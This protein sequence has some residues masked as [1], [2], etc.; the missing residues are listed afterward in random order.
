MPDK[1]PKQKTSPAVWRK[2][3]TTYDDEAGTTL[4]ELAR[5]F[6]VSES[7]IR[8]HS[9]R[10][11]WRQREPE[12]RALPARQ[13]RGT[14]EPEGSALEVTTV[15]P[16]SLPCHTLPPGDPI[17]PKEFNE[18]LQTEAVSWL[19]VIAEARLAGAEIGYDTIELIRALVPQWRTAAEVGRKALGLDQ[20]IAGGTTV[21]VGILG[22]S[23][24]VS[25][26]PNA[27]PLLA[28]TEEA[29]PAPAT[30]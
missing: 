14:H 20:P 23:A 6:G 1:Q 7:A 27:I 12:K 25:N 28:V 21:N 8:Q 24:V 19:D 15:T 18:R 4:T 10:E 22:Q 2:I 11:K 16:L 17:L 3:R 9:A 5:R 29:L 30:P 13:K 26:F